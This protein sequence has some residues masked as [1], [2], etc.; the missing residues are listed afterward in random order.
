MTPP[1]PEPGSARNEDTMIRIRS[2]RG[3]QARSHSE[4][5]ASGVEY[6]LLI[7]GIA[8]LIILSVFAFGGGST[9]LFNDSCKTLFQDR[10]TGTC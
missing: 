3:Y 9:G 2:F 10:G 8:A 6:G 4:R 5:G 1:S 7:A